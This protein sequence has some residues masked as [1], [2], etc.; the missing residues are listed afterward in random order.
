MSPGIS[1]TVWL[2]R[3][4]LDNSADGSEEDE[5]ES[6]E[7]DEDDEEDEEDMEVKMFRCCVK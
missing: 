1:F 6:D 4:K 5:E 7:D 2:Q 3:G